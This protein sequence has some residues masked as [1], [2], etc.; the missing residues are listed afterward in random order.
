M[1]LHSPTRRLRKALS[2]SVC[3][4]CTLPPQKHP[5][6][7][8]SL[9]TDTKLRH[10]NFE[11]LAFP[12]NQFASLDPGT[13]A[14]IQSF[15]Q[16]KYDVSFPV[17]G[18]TEVNGA[19]AEPVWEWMKHSKPGICGLKRVKWNFEKFLIGRDGAVVERWAS[20]TG[21]EAIRARVEAE[22]A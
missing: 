6:L 11:I 1:R 5:P 3:F 4:P 16:S 15:C 21:P 2:R 14:E 9:T 18:K 22:F 17:L 13:N 20:T 19:N 12:C 10:P 8:P 7:T